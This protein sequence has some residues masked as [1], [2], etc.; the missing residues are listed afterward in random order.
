MGDGPADQHAGIGPRPHVTRVGH[1]F[2]AAIDDLPH[3]AGGGSRVA[4]GAVHRASKVVYH[5]TRP[6]PGQGQRMQ[7]ADAAARAGD[8]GDA[9]GKA[10]IRHRGGPR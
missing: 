3:H 7:P 8:H 1:R 5:H 10:P 9:A 6:E 4:A 2:A